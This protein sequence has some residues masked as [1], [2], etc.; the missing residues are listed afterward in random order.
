MPLH[1]TISAPS[2]SFWLP[3]FSNLRLSYLAVRPKGKYY[4]LLS[5]CYG[6]R[7][8]PAFHDDRRL[9]NRFFGSAG[10]ESGRSGCQVTGAGAFE[11]A[12][13]H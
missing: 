4:K 6:R 11:K 7:S 8:P 10:I 5:L 1:R 2:G 13:D 9:S 12:P 3:D